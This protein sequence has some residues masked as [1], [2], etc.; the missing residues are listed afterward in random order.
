[1][2]CCGGPTHGRAGPGLGVDSLP[3]GRLGKVTRMEA[4]PVR[5]MAG[6]RVRHPNRTPGWGVPADTDAVVH[7]GWRVGDVMI[8]AG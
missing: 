7:R 4:K 3:Q 8:M 1:M 6:A 5:D 2:S